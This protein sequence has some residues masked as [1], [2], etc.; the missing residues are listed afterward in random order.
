MEKDSKTHAVIGAAKE[1]H[2]VLGPGFLEAVYQEALAGN[3]P[4]VAFNIG[5]SC[6]GQTNL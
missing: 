6:L 3:S 2:W 5:A 1:A 4:C